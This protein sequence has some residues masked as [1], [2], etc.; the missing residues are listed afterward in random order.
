MPGSIQAFDEALHLDPAIRP[1]LWQRGL[2]LYYAGDHL[3]AMQAHAAWP[4][5]YC[6]SLSLYEYLNAYT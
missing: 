3:E 4:S 1:Y 5:L 6:I 2:S